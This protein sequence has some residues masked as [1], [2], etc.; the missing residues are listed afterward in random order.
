MSHQPNSKHQNDNHSV[1]N[2]EPL[3]NQ[4]NNAQFE[5]G[6]HIKGGPANHSTGHHQNNNNMIVKPASGLPYTLS[7]VGLVCAFLVFLHQQK[8]TAKPPQKLETAVGDSISNARVTSSTP[9]SVTHHYHVLKS[10]NKK[11]QKSSIPDLDEE[12]NTDHKTYTS[13]KKALAEPAQVFRLQLYR[14]NLL[15]LPESIGTLY[16]LQKLYLTSNELKDLPKSFT[17]LGKLTHLYARNNRF[18]KFPESLLTLPRLTSLYLSG[19]KLRKIPDEITQMQGLQILHLSNNRLK[20]LPKQIAQLKNLRILYLKGNP[21][22][23]QEKKK[24][25]RWLPS[26]KIFF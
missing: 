17:H 26:R 9:T 6:L 4:V 7:S 3:Q 1:H 12:A 5:G 24:I 21:I 2:H 22:N 15:S 19:N 8:P 11:Q 20:S 14:K 18:K 25:S 13:L 16:N 23:D 10:M